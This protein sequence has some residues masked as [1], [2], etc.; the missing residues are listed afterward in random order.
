MRAKLSSRCSA[1]LCCARSVLLLLLP[2]PSTPSRITNTRPLYARDTIDDD[3]DDDD[4][5]DGD[6]ARQL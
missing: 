4:D 1:L 2:M 6:E 3:Y 5:D